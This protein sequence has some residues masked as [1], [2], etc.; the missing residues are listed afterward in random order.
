MPT[1]NRL[2]ER[3]RPWPSLRPLKLRQ[4]GAHALSHPPMRRFHAAHTRGRLMSVRAWRTPLTP[5]PC[6]RL[7]AASTPTRHRVQNM[8]KSMDPESL[9]A[10]MQQSGMNVTPE[11][12]RSIADKL[13]SVSGACAGRGW[14][15]GRG[16]RR[17]CSTP[18]QAA[19]TATSAH[20]GTPCLP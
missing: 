1:D 2:V 20:V 16:E 17:E 3:V 7:F 13:D 18:R 4:L 19:R 14:R 11:Q 8:L 15:G 5:L 6:L 9:A 10:A 12:A